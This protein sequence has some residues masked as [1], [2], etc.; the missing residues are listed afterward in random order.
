MIE[1]IQDQLAQKEEFFTQTGSK[2]F[3]TA[4]QIATLKET[5]VKLQSIEE[6]D[7]FE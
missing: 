7:D 4:L 3:K 6:L 5:I 1:V 2:C